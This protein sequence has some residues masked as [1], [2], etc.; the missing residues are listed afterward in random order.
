MKD[1]RR[2]SLDTSAPLHGAATPISNQSGTLN[3][4]H[5]YW[6]LSTLLRFPRHTCCPATDCS[7]W[8]S[9]LTPSSRTMRFNKLPGEQK[10]GRITKDHRVQ[11]LTCA[12]GKSNWG[13]GMTKNYSYYDD[14]LYLK[15]TFHAC[16]KLKGMSSVVLNRWVFRA[17]NA[18]LTWTNT[19]VTY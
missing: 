15:Q 13:E 17:R 19:I 5:G 3:G 10:H 18:I 4:F 11:L 2:P 1:D 9:Q 16:L 8:K 6:K 14:N 12:D 7:V